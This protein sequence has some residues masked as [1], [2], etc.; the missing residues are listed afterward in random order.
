M[1]RGFFQLIVIFLLI[2]VILSLLGVSLSNLTG[3]P[4][5][6]DNLSFLWNWTIFVWDRILE[7]PAKFAWRVWVDLLWEPF[8]ETMQKVKKG[9][10]PKLGE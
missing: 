3:N 5:L 9:E 7:K 1:E 2:V 8:V 4:I 6:Q 10:T